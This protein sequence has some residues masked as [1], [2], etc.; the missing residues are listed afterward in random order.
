[1]TKKLIP[2]CLALVGLVLALHAG[3][4]KNPMRVESVKLDLNPTDC[5]RGSERMEVGMIVKFGNDEKKGEWKQ[6]F[7][8]NCKFTF[9]KD[10]SLSQEGVEITCRVHSTMCTGY[11]PRGIIEATCR[12]GVEKAASDSRSFSCPEN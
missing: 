1:M 8:P 3:D 9:S 2:T 10:V 11:S 4:T 5:L 6:S 12:G 7:N